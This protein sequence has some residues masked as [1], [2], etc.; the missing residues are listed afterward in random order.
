[1]ASSSVAS[2]LIR[3]DRPGWGAQLERLV[4]S[5]SLSM[6][7]ACQQ[8]LTKRSKISV[9]T[10]TT[11]TTVPQDVLTISKYVGDLKTVPRTGWVNRKVPSRIESV[12]EHSYRTAVMGLLLND[13][14]LDVGRVVSIALVHD[15]A[16]SIVGDITPDQGMS[17]EDKR[18]HEEDAMKTIL[19]GKL[20]APAAY[21]KVM[22]LWQ[23]YEDR[24]TPE[25]KTVKDLDRLEM[26]L[27]ANE[28]EIRHPELDLSDFFNSV[29][30]KF[31]HP[32]VNHWF[33]ELE[34]ARNERRRKQS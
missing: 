26:V 32:S 10:T 24:K 28:Y 27:Q 33:E 14:S 2:K 6:E 29:R 17:D 5:G 18:K 15:L 20:K 7:E 23:E 9:E 31:T 21:G 3:L 12:A 34:A 8:L 4:E 25:G 16:E 1:M 11:T 13:E 19:I 30:G 22:E